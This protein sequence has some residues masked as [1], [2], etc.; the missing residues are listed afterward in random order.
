M[1]ISV[2]SKPDCQQCVATKNWLKKRGQDFIEHDISLDPDARVKALSMGFTS[3]PVVTVEDDYGN[4]EDS[5]GG[6]NPG[7]LHHWVDG[8]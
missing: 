4:I 6:L 2:Y 1:V 8:K 5:W 7:K 3:A